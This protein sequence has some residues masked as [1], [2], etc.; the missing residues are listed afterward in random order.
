MIIS[1]ALAMIM[2]AEAVTP[3]RT[4]GDTTHL[5]SSKSQRDAVRIAPPPLSDPACQSCCCYLGVDQCRSN[6]SIGKAV[7][8]T[9]IRGHNAASPLAHPSASEVVGHILPRVG[10]SATRSAQTH[11]REGDTKINSRAPHLL[12]LHILRFGP[13]RYPHRGSDPHTPLSDP[14]YRVCDPGF[15]RRSRESR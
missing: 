1:T 3:T 14:A 10:V 7:P 15:D 9:A 2:R 6:K 11:H 13:T 12:L 5:T 4:Q 8:S